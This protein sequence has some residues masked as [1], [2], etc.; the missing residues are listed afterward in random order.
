MNTDK[1]AVRI[2]CIMSIAFY[3]WMWYIIVKGD[4]DMRYL[5]W[6]MITAVVGGL[7]CVS[8]LLLVGAGIL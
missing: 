2:L 6:A 1:F 3:S 7:A 8:I 5:D 4:E